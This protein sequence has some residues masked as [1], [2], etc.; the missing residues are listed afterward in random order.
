LT[1]H[2][3]TDFYFSH[4]NGNLALP[5]LR[6]PGVR[7]IFE[8][9]VSPENIR[10]IATSASSDDEKLR[11]ITSVLSTMGEI[12]AAYA[13]EVTVGETLV[14][15]LTRIQSFTLLV[16]DTAV[17]L[18]RGDFTDRRRREAWRTTLLGVVDSLAER[19]KYSSGQIVELASAL[20]VHYPAISGIL[21]DRERRDFEHRIH[22]L[23]DSEPDP[24]IKMAYAQLLDAVE[25]SL[26]K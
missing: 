17:Q 1:K 3:Y 5:H 6:E 11:Q 18:S 9:I 19:S 13:Y 24:G 7:A 20:A 2:E 26:A 23:A 4:W 12:R 21:A 22:M 25:K 8:R 10:L 14:E 15:E 16:L